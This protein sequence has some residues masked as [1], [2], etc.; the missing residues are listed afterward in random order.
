MTEISESFLKSVTS[1]YNLSDAEISALH[2][3]LAGQ[4]AESIAETL[5]I[6]APAVRKRLG[7]V[8][9]KFGIAGGTAGKLEVLRSL[10]QEK[11]QLFLVA[12]AESQYDFGEAPDVPIFFGR[13][14]EL[15]R[16]EQWV[17]QDRCR[18]VA[19]FGL[20]G[21]GKTSL[22]VKLAQKVQ[23]QF[24]CVIWRSL[25]HAPTIDDLLAD[26]L[27]F[28]SRNNLH[29]N[30]VS[31]TQITTSQLLGYLRKY[32][33]LLILDNVESILLEGDRTGRYRQGYEEYGELFR[34]V[35]EVPHQSCLILTSRETPK[36]IPLLEGDSLK[37]R[38]L[39]LGGLENIPAKEIFVSKGYFC[40]SDEDWRELINHYAG[41]PLALK[42]VAVTIQEVFGGN[43]SEFI[44]QGSAVFV[45][46]IGNLLEQQFNRLSSV[47]QEI[48]YWIAINF[49]PTSFLE[50]KEDIISGVSDLELIESLESLRRRSLIAN[51][52]GL[53]QYTIQPVVME[54]ILHRFINSLCEEILPEID[55]Q[56]LSLFKNYA[57]LKAQTEGK[58]R[59]IQSRLIVEPIAERLINTFGNKSQIK[60]H[61]LQIISS[62][63]QTTPLTSG[64]AG[65]N[66]INL[67]CHLQ[68]DLSG[69]NF[70]NLKIWQAY[71]IGV[72][73]H[74]VN[75]TN[76]DLS[77]SV[78]TSIFDSILSVTFHPLNG[79]LLA[80]GDVDGRISLWQ[81]SYGEQLFT[82][83][84]HANWVRTV[85]FSPDGKTLAS[86]SDD[87]TIK[88]WD[89]DSQKH[90]K[91]LE[92]HSNW[93]RSIAYGPQGNILASG[94]SDET[95]RLW[96]TRTQKCLKII[97][98]HNSFIRAIAFSFDGQRLASGSADQTVRLWDAN[99]G[100]CLK[101]LAGHTKLVQSVAFSPD[102][103]ILASG[104]D[105]KTVRL[106]DVATGQ[107][108]NILEGHKNLVQS[109][110]F[111]PDGK[112]LASGSDDKT[113][114]FWDVTTG[115]C[116]NILEGHTNSVRSVTFS[117]DG[118]TLASGSDDKTVRFW[119]VATGQCIQILQGYTNWI[120]DLAVSPDGKTLASSSDDKTVRLWNVQT[121]EC[122]RT[123]EGHT[124]RVWSVAFSPIVSGGL[125][126]S[127]GDDK[128]VR[129]WDIQTGKLIRTLQNTDRVRSVAFS[130]DGQTLATGSGDC[131]IKLW[132][133]RTGQYFEN[134][135]GHQNWVQ[136]VAFS[137]D[138]ETL[139]SG[140]NDR[141]LRIWNIHTG[142]CI[143]T[144]EGHT[145]RI[146]S[147]AFSPDNQTLASGSDDKT[148]RLWD[149]RT[150][151]CYKTLSCKDW[152]RS[153]AFSPQGK[154]LA[155][156]CVNH[157][158]QIWDVETGENL[159]TF[160]GH[161]NWVRSVVF[162]PDGQLLYSG[163]QDGTIKQWDVKTGECLKT[164][165]A[166]RPYEG[167]IITNAV[168]LTDA[169]KDTLK[170][171]GAI[172]D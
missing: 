12:S 14:E 149:I 140:S 113:V 86:S 167:M 57:L 133:V 55:L 108:L 5:K 143:Q 107:C 4:T 32:R 153:V 27:Q 151:Q 119:D 147:V 123:L 150:G 58:T 40:G 158:I 97:K 51:E 37:V 144:L 45:G 70:G 161:N 91:T 9:Q 16:L 165:I 109:V 24:E 117:P 2:L 116:L 76:S 74:N 160:K 139:S 6:S 136:S 114:R 88:L 142:K 20:G 52:R 71:L 36:E 79:D 98:G 11:S 122:I 162:S 101:I 166:K 34:Q 73:L 67:L 66:V 63:Q 7:S 145:M 115:Q 68:I 159:N 30:D 44:S 102:G 163:S 48:L 80:T 69:C 35:G 43:I 82:W 54:Y 10:L 135:Q 72:N 61:L 85:A 121:S 134:L 15:A 56:K 157:T 50:L 126:V 17:I 42:I 38:A 47:E 89:V 3:A 125:L 105:D 60:E 94:S 81:T 132:N 112:I 62:I 22:S 137:S 75:F 84:A 65:G 23:N 41:N 18:L 155:S 21:I 128:T 152:V 141:T 31:D 87:H 19:I 131:N 29:T 156:G 49:K 110:A 26:L 95:L 124:M 170:E 64:Y 53:A 130:P 96:D 8:Y 1:E 104:S 92:G 120:H 33:C 168:G 127:G 25:R 100:E 28:L 106:W 13:T 59:N 129:L 146:W 154:V 83:K 77:K 118:N 78:F 169:Q 39:Q 103:K 148:I 138:G 111:S 90:I 171:L 99:T 164:L 172:A 46:N 93:I